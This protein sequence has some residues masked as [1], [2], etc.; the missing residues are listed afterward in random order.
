MIIG[1][2]V[3]GTHIDGVIIEDRK[4][5]KKNKI[6]TGEDLFENIWI[7]IKDLIQDIDKDKISRINL[8]TTVSTNAIIEDTTSKVGMFIQTGAGRNYDFLTPGDENINLS[9]S[10]DHRGNL[11]KSFKKREILDS[12]QDFKDKEIKNCGIVT[13]FSTR[14]PEEELKGQE[15]LKDNSMEHIS[16]GHR[17][18]GNL[19]FPRR[20]YTT[21]LNEA[22]HSIWNNFITSLDKSLER[23]GVD[24]PIYVLKADG[25]TMEV[26][27]A[28]EKPVETILSGPAASFM[29]ISSMFEIYG[30]AILLDIGGTTT[31]IFFLADGVTLFEPLGIQIKD[32][33]TLVRA[34]YSVSIGL[35]GDSSLSI[36]DDDIEIGPKRQ[37]IAV[38]LG[39]KKPTPTDAMIALELIEIGDRELSKK[40]I[41]EFGKALDLSMEETANK[42]LE[43]MAIKI[44][45]KI[46]ETL[47]VINSQPVY[48]I[49]ELLHGKEIKPKEIKIIGGPAKV[50]SS[51][52]EKKMGIPCEYPEDYELANA[53]GACLSKPTREINLLADSQ[54]GILSIPELGIY[55]KINKRYDQKKTEERAIEIL[56]DLDKEDSEIEIIESN[57][58]NMIDGFRTTGK[59]IRVKAQI[60]PSLIYRLEEK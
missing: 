5:I 28:N 40:A 57:S 24:A 54:K 1:I 38:G 51:I 31:D 10:I 41:E 29:G 22:V 9:G 17:I 26:D 2:D 13:K 34:I 55:E 18:S 37:G 23:E 42:I 48:T 11:I 27:E 45:T 58:F 39:G 32:Y 47:A 25:G 30:D 53:I 35:G 15:I 14:N 7:L 21:Y 60:R 56:R 8:S 43:N 44:K 52:L 4:I 19:N 36:K 59:N 16:M 6:P 49:E 12:L 33:K 50:M 20:V 3:G 46:H